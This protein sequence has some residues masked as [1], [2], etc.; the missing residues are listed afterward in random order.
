MPLFGKEEEI[1]IFHSWRIR[2]PL[3]LLWMKQITAVLSSLL[4]GGEIY[5]ISSGKNGV[6]NFYSLH[7]ERK[8]FRQYTQVRGGVFEPAVS[9]DG[10]RVVLSAYEKGRFS[11]YLFSLEAFQEGLLNV[12]EKELT[13]VSEKE[14]TYPSHLYQPQFRLDYI[15]PWFSFAE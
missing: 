10:T 5:F 14:V 6:F 3:V 15:L 8:E 12:R 13:L 7:P 9:P 1:S 11:L 4:K 2:L